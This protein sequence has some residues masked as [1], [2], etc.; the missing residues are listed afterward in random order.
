MADKPK[1]KA[2]KV[3][4]SPAI[5]AGEPKVLL[6]WSSRAWPFI[7][8]SREFFKTIFVIAAL[9]VLIAIF[10][11][12]TLL[13]LVIVTLAFVV[14]VLGTVEPQEISHRLT[15]RGLESGEHRYPWDQLTRFWFGERSGQQMLFVE[16][17][18]RFPKRLMLVAEN[19]DRDKL[20]ALLQKKIK[21]VEEPEPGFLDQSARY[22]SKKI[23][24][25][26]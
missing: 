1:D 3:G 23:P 25:E 6:E 5:S 17:T 7:K 4:V 9:L 13:A 22:L 20:S 12:E 18:L 16:T 24:L 2:A 14:Y 26:S 8:R 11:R 19:V 10:M 15:E 21:L